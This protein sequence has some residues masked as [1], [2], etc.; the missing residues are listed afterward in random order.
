MRAAVRMLVGMLAL[1]GMLATATAQEYG[2]PP[3]D[4]PQS[5]GGPGYAPSR[6]SVGASLLYLKPGAGNL[7]YGTLVSPLPAVSPHWVNQAID[8]NYAPAFDVALRYN[9]AEYGLDFRANWTHLDTDDGHSFIADITQFAGPPYE[10]GPDANLYKLGRGTVSHTF[11]AINLDAGYL[12]GNGGPA[13]VR[14]FG[15]IQFANIEQTL[16]GEFSS[17]NGTERI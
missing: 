9:L 14:I 16:T 7:E 5:N 8:P 13:Q 17:F 15:G 2:P 12:V 11:D 3:Q 4:Y 6:L 1:G 10:I